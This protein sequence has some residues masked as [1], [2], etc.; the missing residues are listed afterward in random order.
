MPIE[1][2]SRVRFRGGR[3]LGES[4]DSPTGSSR[5]GATWLRGSLLALC[6]LL[7]GCASTRDMAFCRER[8]AAAGGR[9]GSASLGAG[10]MLLCTCAF[11]VEAT[12]E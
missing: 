6:L 9:G 4:F 5:A 12:D 3:W 1:R 2:G 8:C 10:N 7:T 11:P